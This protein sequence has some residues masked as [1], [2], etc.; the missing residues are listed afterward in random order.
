MCSCRKGIHNIRPVALKCRHESKPDANFLLKKPPKTSFDWSDKGFLWNTH[1][2][3]TCSVP[4]LL[5]VY[6]TANDKLTKFYIDAKA[7]ALN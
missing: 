5:D 7:F 3:L 6:A 2:S 4:L 1:K